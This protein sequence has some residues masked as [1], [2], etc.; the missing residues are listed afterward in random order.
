MQSAKMS[1]NEEN[2]FQNIAIALIDT[3]K[4]ANKRRKLVRTPVHNSHDR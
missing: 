3:E 1:R 2:R 4:K